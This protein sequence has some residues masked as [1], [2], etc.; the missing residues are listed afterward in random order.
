M[1]LGAIMVRDAMEVA[2]VG[3][4]VHDQN[5]TRDKGGPG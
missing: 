5:G 4:F 2:P 3:E 1:K